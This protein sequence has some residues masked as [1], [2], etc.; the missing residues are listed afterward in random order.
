MKVE[1]VAP[2]NQAHETFGDHAGSQCVSNA[3]VFLLY[4]HYRQR[5]PSVVDDL[6]EVLVQGSALDLE[7]RNLSIL[8]NGDYAQLVDIPH[9]VRSKDWA[10]GIFCSYEFHGMINTDSTIRD[11]YIIPLMELIQTNLAGPTKYLIIICND[12][13]VAILIQNAQI[14]I[15]DPHGSLSLNIH[16]AF[17]A[18]SYNVRDIIG[19]IGGV[20]DVYTACFLYPVPE[21]YYGTKDIYLLD[22]YRVISSRVYNDTYVDLLHENA[23]M[24]KRDDT[25]E[26]TFDVVSTN[27]IQTKNESQRKRL[28]P[29]GGSVTRISMSDGHPMS[30]K[31]KIVQDNVGGLSSEM[32]DSIIDLEDNEFIFDEDDV[33]ID[34]ELQ[35]LENIH[36]DVNG[37]VQLRPRETTDYHT[38]EF[39]AALELDDGA[40]DMLY[41][42]DTLMGL[43][44]MS[45]GPVINDSIYGKVPKDVKN[46]EELQRCL[47]MIVFE[48]G[49]V[50]SPTVSKVI[51]LIKFIIICFQRLGINT[52]VL[53][54]LLESNMDLY[55]LYR[56]V[57]QVTSREQD[58]IY[59]LIDKLN[60]CLETMYK[61][62]GT[63]VHGGASIIDALRTISSE[64]MRKIRVLDMRE[65]V[66]MVFNGNIWWI[67]TSS[68]WRELQNFMRELRVLIEN[69]NEDISL[70]GQRYRD[71]LGAFVRLE[72]V[73]IDQPL[74]MDTERQTDIISVVGE[75][76]DRLSQDVEQAVDVMIEL[77]RDD[78]ITDIPDLDVTLSRIMIT[79]RTVQWFKDFMSVPVDHQINQLLNLGQQVAE[80][81]GKDW[82]L[83]GP[84]Q[85]IPIVAVDKLRNVMEVARQT[86]ETQKEIDDLVTMIESMLS[87][88]DDAM[89][90]LDIFSI[91]VI[92]SY[93]ATAKTLMKGQHSDKIEHLE[94]IVKNLSASQKFVLE[95]IDKMTLQSVEYDMLRVRDAIINNELL[96]R[97]EEISQKLDAKLYL[98]CADIIKD[99]GKSDG[100]ADR[101]V[102]YAMISGGA[103]FKA[104]RSREVLELVADLANILNDMREGQAV[105]MDFN[106]F[107][108]KL[109]DSNIGYIY[110]KDL[111]GIVS[112]VQ[113]RL[114]EA[115][116]KR[117]RDKWWKFVEAI[118][119]RDT[120]QVYNALAAAATD[121]DRERAQKY[122]SSKVGAK[123]P[124][125]VVDQAVDKVI[126][127]NVR[128]VSIRLKAAFENLTF[129]DISG[130]DW[131]QLLEATKD[132]KLWFEID[133]MVRKGFD[134]IRDVINTHISQ[135][136]H[137]I[138]IGTMQETSPLPWLSDFENNV[139][140]H[141]VDRPEWQTN[142]ELAKELRK[143]VHV[144]KQVF[145]ATDLKQATAGTSLE[146]TT[147]VFLNIL[148]TVEHAVDDYKQGVR[149]EVYDF[150]SDTQ[151]MVG[152][153]VDFPAP[154]KIII[155]KSVL[156]PQNEEKISKLPE[157]YR[158]MIKEKERMMVNDITNEFS[159]FTLDIQ[160]LREEFE[161]GKRGVLMILYDEIVNQLSKSPPDVTRQIVDRKNPLKVLEDM[162]AVNNLNKK[163]Y[164]EAVATCRWLMDTCKLL[165]VTAPADIVSKLKQIMSVVEPL[166]KKI[167][168]LHSL[169]LA[170]DTM[171][172]PIALGQALNDL[173]PNRIKGGKKR[174]DDT[175]ERK[176][177]LEVAAQSAIDD[178]EF[179]AMLQKL[180]AESRD[181]AWEQD[182]KD[183]LYE[184]ELSIQKGQ[185][186]GVRERNPPIFKNMHDV[187]LYIKWK[188]EFIVTNGRRYRELFEMFA[189]PKKIRDLN[190]PVNHTR[191]LALY[192][193]LQKPKSVL[194]WVEILRG[195]TLSLIPHGNKGKVLELCHVLDNVFDTM[196]YSQQICPS[197]IPGRKPI[198]TFLDNKFGVSVARLLVGHWEDIEANMGDII[199]AYA[200]SN[201]SGHTSMSQFLGMVLV[202]YGLELTASHMDNRRGPDDRV[203]TLTSKQW[204]PMI[205]AFFPYHL[206][207]GLRATSYSSMLDILSAVLYQARKLLPYKFL[208][209][210]VNKGRRIPRHIQGDGPDLPTY[211][212]ASSVWNQIHVE[213]RLW[214]QPRF[215]EICGL[216]H[217]RARISTLIW[218]VQCLN[219]VILEQLWASCK[220]ANMDKKTVADYVALMQDAVYGPL[221]GIREISNIVTDGD[222]FGTMTGQALEVV[223]SKST[224]KVPPVCAFEVIVAC[225][226][227]RV[228]A[229]LYVTLDSDLFSD[230]QLGVVKVISLLLDC[231]SKVEPYKGMYEAPRK[232]PSVNRIKEENVCTPIDM[233]ILT[234]QVDWLQSVFGAEAES[235][236]MVVLVDT[237]NYVLHTYE[238]TSDYVKNRDVDFTFVVNSNNL[239]KRLF[240]HG[241]GVTPHDTLSHYSGEIRTNTKVVNLENMFTIFP[242][243]LSEPLKDDDILDVYDTPHEGAALNNA[244]LVYETTIPT[245]RRWDEGKI[246]L[247]QRRDKDTYE[248]T[249]PRELPTIKYNPIQP[250][251]LQLKNIQVESNKHHIVLPIQEA[252]TQEDIFID[253]EQEKRTKTSKDIILGFIKHIKT[254]IKISTEAVLDTIQRIKLL[255]LYVGVSCYFFFGLGLGPVG[256]RSDSS[257][258]NVESSGKGG[259]DVVREELELPVCR[260]EG[261]ALREV[262]KNR[263]PEVLEEDGIPLFEER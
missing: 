146:D 211:L 12:K 142:S 103:T 181:A 248:K 192:F 262:G 114:C 97:A 24:C 260:S 129:T 112:K 130:T 263:C 216:S 5:P 203:V 259:K 67:L 49:V 219:E 250:Q 26:I 75:V 111:M 11:E 186:S 25:E 66:D 249:C 144:F 35:V 109:T 170:L 215:L 8:K 255:Y 201:L 27:L 191:R 57:C 157:V 56:L 77:I 140:F 167:E 122:L 147:N 83:P 217:E 41:K 229:Q 141:L 76:V 194:L 214:A 132:P 51:N 156:G 104:N 153:D 204:V 1:L 88:Q 113:D 148:W 92:E 63:N 98:L 243:N 31:G 120:Q 30:K 145:S 79:V 19:L 241:T 47:S 115:E 61:N 70:D 163:N 118:D 89:E 119:P 45:S 116:L 207:T 233:A 58:T 232:R 244:G 199:G 48:Y 151:K 236:K 105:S 164:V 179:A 123:M 10:Y 55:E 212:F 93:L 64:A 85:V 253:A 78:V 171:T 166:H 202:T 247:L 44:H 2:Y 17:I 139:L 18:S 99:M 106:A 53:E 137:S 200:E 228:K 218:A 34:D 62:N 136:L 154:P 155:P 261:T 21:R 152:Q 184:A 208:S 32:Q 73:H 95:V 124:L 82:P 40:Q 197:H 188:L 238:P 257:S 182:L 65:L 7:L 90:G 240:Y 252:L 50:I 254:R 258:G 110:R 86:R 36:D 52:S 209:A 81:V 54:K 37:D 80:M 134:R 205:T 245:G 220:P 175:V 223:H 168:D 242:E 177:Q 117:T 173:D 162:G 59:C 222:G 42:L 196:I 96:V 71:V 16:G 4:C 230:R 100:A 33:F 234:L 174:Y 101:S 74:L 172:D 3:T 29:C 20:V 72:P 226:M 108:K 256:I 102:L 69:H 135:K 138:V 206:A 15:F 127:E 190:V 165:I 94:S 91:N 68:E 239:P 224:I 6:L 251:D 231:D 43:K 195:Q 23:P 126:K 87:H 187:S 193:A 183:L 169:D 180:E 143:L 159:K 198:A 161:A 149:N 133:A 185:T 121:D 246:E 160:T 46:I 131:V 189:L 237:G 39:T 235:D 60:H 9:R 221:P 84:E 227:F 22:N 178:A 210:K 176:K 213:D 158:T 14:F 107:K 28:K 38:L 128:T 125:S 13:A 150:I 225:L